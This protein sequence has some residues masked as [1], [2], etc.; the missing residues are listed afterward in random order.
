ME[1]IVV[2][3]RLALSQ[4]R[5]QTNTDRQKVVSVHAIVKHTTCITVFTVYGIYTTQGL[6]VLLKAEPEEV[7]NYKTVT[8]TMANSYGS[9]GLSVVTQYQN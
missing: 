4:D 1:Y 8:S 2:V 5:Q 3:N 9:R 6:Y 7:G